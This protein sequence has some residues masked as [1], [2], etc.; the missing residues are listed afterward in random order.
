MAEMP[1]G[2]AIVTIQLH[3][4]CFVLYMST[5]ADKGINSDSVIFRSSYLAYLVMIPFFLILHQ[6]KAELDKLLEAKDKALDPYESMEKE[7]TQFAAKEKEYE[8]KFNKMGMKLNASLSS[9]LK[10]QE[11][12]EA[13]KV[14]EEKAN[15]RTEA[16]KMKAE[17]K[18]AR[19]EEAIKKVR[20]RMKEPGLQLRGLGMRRLRPSR[21]W[22]LGRSL[23][24]STP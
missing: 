2:D 8:D 19:Y 12:I 4:H 9:E 22:K 11:E 13:L 15:Q 10:L 20:R 1:F 21:L 3:S 14:W 23:P 5:M 24:S 17:E 7:Q 18:W 16:E 6:L